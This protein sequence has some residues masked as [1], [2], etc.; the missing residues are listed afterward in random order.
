[1][2]FFLKFS[3]FSIFL[4]IINSYS[5]PCD[6]P[7]ITLTIPIY[8]GASY[9]IWSPYCRDS[10]Q[11]L[12]SSHYSQQSYDIN[13]MPFS[14]PMGPK[15]INYQIPLIPYDCDPIIW[16]QLRLLEVVQYVIDM[17][18]NY[19]HHYCPD[20]L[21]NDDNRVDIDSDYDDT[22]G[23][24]LRKDNGGG[25]YL[26]RNSFHEISKNNSQSNVKMKGFLK[27][28]DKND[29]FDKNIFDDEKNISN[30]SNISGNLDNISISSEKKYNDNIEKVN[31]DKN[32][33]N[34][35]ILRNI[36]KSDDFN[37]KSINYRSH[38]DNNIT[39]TSNISLNIE[40]LPIS[41]EN[42]SNSTSSPPTQNNE[43]ITNFSNISIIPSNLTN[44]TNFTDSPLYKTQASHDF[45][46]NITS[47]KSSK[48]QKF[49]QKSNYYRNT[50]YQGLDSATFISYIFN[51][52]LGAYFPL[53]IDNLACGEQAP[54]K[55]I[56][57]SDISSDIDKL[58]TG[59]LLFLKKNDIVY[60]VVL[61][62]GII[63][64]DDSGIFSY[65]RILD[66]YLDRRRA[67]LIEEI[68]TAR[69]NSQNIFII[70]DSSNDGPNYRLFLG[71]DMERVAFVRRVIGED[72]KYRGNCD[73]LNEDWKEGDNNGWSRGRSHRRIQDINQEN[74]QSGCNTGNC[75]V[76]TNTVENVNVV[77]KVFVDQQNN[78]N[79]MFL[80]K[81]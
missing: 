3:I 13:C 6:P 56:R 63:A 46:L 58:N 8:G 67:I 59:D 43:N 60:K 25:G 21:P 80:R 75:D 5:S 71:E 50:Q 30:N 28:F 81:F 64:T 48:S 49:L 73:N 41:L 55:F 7:S 77:V 11:T 2:K 31:S 42:S 54:G 17:G 1:M 79:S 35:S 52:A 24:C 4:K 20:W 23:G 9:V 57:I 68:R 22:A 34:E 76:T 44:N 18:L 51:M 14:D 33:R 74:V 45:L 36:H 69:R 16:Q 66:N 19:C 10:A 12:S 70:A 32:A 27:N 65:E 62:T 26:R 78:K 61:W 40:N 47:N 37:T 53:N 38:D 39:N 72:G 29:E 15:P